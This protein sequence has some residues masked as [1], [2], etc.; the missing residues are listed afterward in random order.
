MHV[1][2]IEIY[3]NK[4]F[5]LLA[6]AE[7]GQLRV[8]DEGPV[9]RRGSSSPTPGAG[10][11]AENKRLDIHTHP[12]IGVYVDNLSEIA[13]ETVRDVARL[14]ALGEKYRHTAT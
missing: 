4:L 5:D 7:R 6:T 3:N 2:Y 13:V 12:T 8:P 10:K 9:K 1:S 14:V 11:R